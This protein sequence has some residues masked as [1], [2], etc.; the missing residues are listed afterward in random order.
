M[1]GAAAGYFGP[2]SYP[3][4]LDAVQ[5]RKVDYGSFVLVEKGT[6][7]KVYSTNDPWLRYMLIATGVKGYA[8]WNWW[9]SPPSCAQIYVVGGGAIVDLSQLS[10]SDYPVLIMVSNPTEFPW[11][12][13]CDSGDCS[14]STEAS[15]ITD[16]NEF[17]SGATT[18]YEKIVVSPLETPPTAPTPTTTPSTQP[19]TT[20]QPTQPVAAAGF[21]AKDLLLAGGVAAALLIALYA[22]T[23]R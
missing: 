9:N 1:A 17:C 6:R 19:T 3:A 12:A 15:G 8:D 11:F 7:I 2:W 22:A 23:R 4:R 10:D 5:L 14:F 13:E 21:T 18:G 16:A 20:Q